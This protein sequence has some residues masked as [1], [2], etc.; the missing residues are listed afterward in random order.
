VKKGTGGTDVCVSRLFIYYNARVADA[1]ENSGGDSDSV[2]VTDS[3]ATITNTIETLESIGC[4]LES[5]WPYDISQVNQKPSDEAY[6]EA[7]PYK[8]SEAFQVNVDLTEMKKCLAQG[9]PFAFG[10]VLYPSY[11]NVQSDGIV[12]MPGSDEETEGGHCQLAV[13][14]DDSTQSF[15][16]RNSWGAGW[17]CVCVAIE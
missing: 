10:L 6:A 12:P 17:V 3:G 15:I 16:V 4:C 9:F 8:I 11:N 13:G 1:T 14:Y 7:P 5:T 2:E